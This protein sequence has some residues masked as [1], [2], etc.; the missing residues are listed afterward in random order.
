MSILIRIN[1]PIMVESLKQLSFEM[2]LVR[3]Y[4]GND[5]GKYI[6]SQWISSK[7]F[8]NLAGWNWSLCSDF[9][10]DFLDKRP[11]RNLEFHCKI[12]DKFPQYVFL[13]PMTRT[14]CRLYYHLWKMQK[15]SSKYETLIQKDSHPVWRRYCFGF[16]VVSPPVETSHILVLILWEA[17]NLSWL[18]KA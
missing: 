18:A 7:I 13:T 16:N 4:H 17:L 14:R 2:L 6:I 12:T 3:W 10:W 15:Y 5:I 11:L 1:C 9:T 8:S